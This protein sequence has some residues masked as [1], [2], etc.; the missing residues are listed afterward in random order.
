MANRVK[1]GIPG[2]DKLMQGGFVES[3]VNLVTGETGTG[4]T[5]FG[6]QY[7]HS[8]LKRGEPGVY[9]TL[10]ENP[11]DIKADAMQFGWNLEKFEKSGIFKLIYHDPVQVN[12]IDSVIIG[13]INSL[14]AKRLVIDSTSLL[15][16][17][18]ENPAQIRRRTFSIINTIKRNACTALILSEIP[19]GVKSLSR[20]GVEEF[21][22]DSVIVLHYLGIGEVSARSLTIRKMRRTKHGNDVYPLEI[23]D[24]GIVV[25]RAEI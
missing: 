15:G 18:I 13:E 5:I 19:E 6:L 7:I 20:F 12:N 8:G 17:N 24:K 1:S 9:I 14:K 22:A 3:S 16:L 21:V 2:L 25:K 10:E 23:S 11:E 4:K